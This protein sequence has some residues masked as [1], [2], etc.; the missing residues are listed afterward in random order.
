MLNNENMYFPNI[1]GL[2][3]VAFLLVFFHHFLIPDFT[4]NN[5]FI[6]KISSRGWS[7]VELFFVL[8]AFLLTSL[9]IKEFKTKNEI[10]VG[11]YF[12]RRILR[13]WPLYFLYILMI[14]LLYGPPADIARFLG[15]VTFTDNLWSS[16]LSYN[17]S[18]NYATHLWTI[19]M[20]EQF[21]IILPF[22]IPFL[23]KLKK[24]T[25]LYVG[26]GIWGMFIAARLTAVLLQMPHPFIWVLPIQGDAFL[27]GILAALG[28][29]DGLFKK[30]NSSLK[31]L[32][33]ISLL[34]LS[35]FIPNVVTI[36]YGQLFLYSVIAFGFLFIMASVNSNNIVLSKIFGNRPIR[37]LGKISYGLY[38]YHIIVTTYVSDWSYNLFSKYFNITNN[39]LIWFLCFIVTLAAVILVSIISYELYEK[40]FIKLKKRFTI[41]FSRPEK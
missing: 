22:I 1:D 5:A 38:V 33:G 40:H 32:I 35:T 9:L 31:M 13:I 2:R 17:L 29:F 3:F 10:S 20:E 15:M 28:T 19:S 6:T 41:I 30:I 14:I 39:N 21:Y 24:R 27:F 8:S 4:I 34:I 25:L 37:Y 18:I 12:L 36:G 11:K 16:I 23:L 26:L 7:G